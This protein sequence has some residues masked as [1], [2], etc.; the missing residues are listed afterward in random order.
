MDLRERASRRRQAALAIIGDL[1]L[2]GRWAPYV[3]PHLVG[4]VALDL[5][6]E[7]DIDLE[8][9]SA[10]PMIDHGFRVL[11]S[12]AAL[13]GI[14]RARFTNALDWDDQGLYFQVQYERSGQTWKID[15]W[16]L[17]DDHPGPCARDLVQPLLSVLTPDTRDLILAIKETAAER[18]EPVHG[19]RIY[20]AVLEAGVTDYAGFQSWNT[21][22]PSTLTHWR[23]GP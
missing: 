6:V 12:L 14:R 19:I 11:S 15:M 3:E 13:P 8:I 16:S 10:E 5:V 1:D 21:C 23:P 9:Y 4:S 18:A 17:P 2:F 22:A 20:Q 7:P